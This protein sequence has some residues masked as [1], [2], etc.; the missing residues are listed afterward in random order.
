VHDLADRG[1]EYL[2]DGASAVKIDGQA[3]IDASAWFFID[4]TTGDL[5]LERELDR[6]TITAFAINIIARDFGAP[7]KSARTSVF[8][9][10]DDVNDNAPTF[11]DAI[12]AA[13]VR[14]EAINGED[15]IAVTATDSDVGDNSALAYSIV[16]GNDEGLFF[17]AQGSNMISVESSLNGSSQEQYNLTVTAS[18]AGSPRL[19]GSV[20]VVV[21]VIRFGAPF[22]SNA[23]YTANVSE[24]AQ[25]GV[26]VAQ[27]EAFPAEELRNKT[28]DYAI[29]NGDTKGAFSMSPNGTI[30]V[31]GGLD[32][33]TRETYTLTVRAT[34]YG[35]L[36]KVNTATVVVTVLDVNDNAPYVENS[37]NNPIMAS[38]RESA[39]VGDVVE[40][41]MGKDADMGENQRLSYIIS[42]GNTNGAFS[43]GGEDGKIRVA[44]PLVGAVLD[45]YNLTVIVAD[46]GSPSQKSTFAVNVTVIHFGPPVFQSAPFSVHK[47]ESLQLDQEVATLVA[48]PLHDLADQ[49]VDYE[50]VSVAASLVAGGQDVDASG[51]FAVGRSSGSVTLL[52]V[53]DREVVTKFTVM[54]CATDHGEPR[55]SSTAVLTVVVDDVNDNAPQFQELSYTATI[56]EDHGLGSPLLTLATADADQGD[57]AKVEYSMS[58]ENSPD[59]MF[60][61]S[62]I[63]G[64]VSVGVDLDGL[65]HSTHTFKVRATDQGIPQLWTEVTVTVIVTLV[66]SLSLSPPYHM[67]T[68]IQG[69]TGVDGR[70]RDFS[71]DPAA[72]VAIFAAE[73]R[74]GIW[75]YRTDDDV[76]FLRFEKDLQEANSFLLPAATVFRFTPLAGFVGVATM[77]FRA[78]NGVSATP[79]KVDSRE[80][81]FSDAIGLIVAFV[82]PPKPRPVLG[83]TKSLIMP[84]IPEDIG[85]LENGGILVDLAADLVLFDDAL[86]GS[87]TPI[88]GCAAENQM[89]SDCK[90][91]SLTALFPGEVEALNPSLDEGMRLSLLDQANGAWEYRV[92]EADDWKRLI[93]SDVEARVFRRSHHIRFSPKA[94]YNGPAL[95]K[96]RG[97]QGKFAVSAGVAATATAAVSVSIN[98]NVQPVRDAPRLLQSR[99][100]LPK[101]LPYHLQARPEGSAVEDILRG[102][103]SHPDGQ[104]AGMAVVGVKNVGK[105]SGPD[106]TLSCK[107]VWQFTPTGD[108]ASWGSFPGGT[109][110]DDTSPISPRSSVLLGPRARVRFVPRADYL[111]PAPAAGKE[112]MALSFKVCVGLCSSC[113]CLVICFASLVYQSA[114]SCLAEYQCPGCNPHW[115]GINV[116]DETYTG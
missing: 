85:P 34:D 92:T 106:A 114:G 79:A 55:K 90:P 100:S 91:D 20:Q 19:S 31:V 8:I 5:W 42:G 48:T 110:G 60:N 16:A 37:P 51:Q 72:K 29:T 101:I 7:R 32:R 35:P 83:T 45:R 13:A 52:S 28:I 75:E 65:T 66:P 68:S 21:S 50:M 3:I 47:P 116:L 71:R 98:I 18:D 38:V 46:F 73:E 103:T 87:S 78:Y 84:A 41:I 53:M 24:S 69:A 74:Y 99:F 77:K 9:T 96:M 40:E 61:V 27:V 1:I 95:L 39:A 15:V 107:G 89:P 2:L 4:G 70:L 6:E 67:V 25:P 49:S 26:V 64:I 33:E 57:N 104:P 82:A 115:L 102:K 88:V 22:F 59:T 62:G 105:C 113:T 63:G 36:R 111:W 23:S 80:S 97:W 30:I 14:E 11:P 86:A 93:A 56:R 109:N 76:G 94:N 54:V 81:D 58:P 12:V 108:L 44:T 17:I 10:I 43:I 112:E